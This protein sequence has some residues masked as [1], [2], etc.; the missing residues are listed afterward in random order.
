MNCID[1]DRGVPLYLKRG[2][3]DNS[4]VNELFFYLLSK[5]VTSNPCTIWLCGQSL[6]EDVAELTDASYVTRRQFKS[7]PDL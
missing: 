5:A 4:V 3:A 7:G 6:M 2:G 1:P